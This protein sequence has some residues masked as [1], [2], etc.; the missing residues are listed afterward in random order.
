[1]L[2]VVEDS[3]VDPVRK[4]RAATRLLRR[5]QLRQSATDAEAILWTH[6]RAHRF[7]D[8]KFRRQHPCGPFIIDFF[9]V[10]RKLAIELDGGQHFEPSAEGYD[11]RR[12]AYL[13]GR[14]VTTL[15]FSNDLV[16]EEIEGVL[17]VIAAA[18]GMP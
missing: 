16:F 15:R 7:A 9:C 6:L 1:M 5:R 2:P 14:G 11:A 8:F 18:L 3:F 17:A 13:T 4:Q 10:R 12:T